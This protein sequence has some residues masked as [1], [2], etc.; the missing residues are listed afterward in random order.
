M[1]RHDESK[2]SEDRLMRLNQ[3]AFEV[4]AEIQMAAMEASTRWAAEIASFMARRAQATARDVARMATATTPRELVN[5]QIDRVNGMVEDYT[6]EAGRLM[7]IASQT[8]HEGGEGV[9][10]AFLAERGSGK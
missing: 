5:A 3:E 4:G 7:E 10:S 8:A 1:S 6:H 9:R 2:T